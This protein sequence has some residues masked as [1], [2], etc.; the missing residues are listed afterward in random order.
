MADFGEVT[1]T[2]NPMKIPVLTLLG[3]GAAMASAPAATGRDYPYTPVPFTA[4][5]VADS[6]WSPRFE[7]NRLTTVWYDFKKCEETGRIDNFSKAAGLMPGGFRGTPF[8]DSDVYKVIEGAAYILA[9]QPD[10]KLDAY[11]DA[12]IAKIAAAQEPD[13]Y[14]YTA[15]RLFTPE[16]M[17]GMS[18]RTRWSNLEASHELYNVGHLYEAAVAHFQ[19]TGKKTLLNVA[20]KNADFLCATFGP[21]KLQEPPGHQEI[22]IGL[23]KLFRAV[24]NE[25][26][27]DLA[28]FY[29]DLRGRA[30]THRLRGEYQ[31]DHQ[32]VV[33]Q[34][35]AVGHAVRAG[36]LYS[37]V[38]DV[39][40]LTG[41]AEYVAAIDRLW[42]DVTYRKLHLTGGIGASPGG[43]AFGA[44]YEL[45]NRT[46]YLET[47]AAIANGLWNHRMFLL[48]GDAKYLDVLERVLYNGFLSGVAQTGD[49]FFYPNPLEA[50]GRQK[51]N[52]GSNER[53][54]WFG[55]SCCPVNVVRFVPSIA[56]YVYATRGEALYVNLF[57][58]GTAQ[59]QL[60]GRNVGVVQ[61]TRYPWEGTTRLTLDP[62][63]PGAFAVHVRIPGWALGRPLPGDLYTYEG[64]SAEAPVLKVNG[65]VVPVKLEKGFAV[66]DRSWA[67]GDVIELSLPMPVRRVLAHAKV[68]ADKGR[69]A[70][71]RGPVVYCAEGADHDGQALNLALPDTAEFSLEPQPAL[72]NGVTVI[73]ASGLARQ[74]AADGSAVVQPASLK[75]IPYY[76][77]NHR[78]PNEMA[79]WLPRSAELASIA[80]PLTL[81]GTSRPSA[82]HLWEA[83][84][85][86]ALNDGQEPK[87]SADHDLPRFSW[88]PR[89]GSAEWVQY[90][91]KKPSRVESV[92]VYWF[93][94]TGRGQ[95]RV[96]RSWRVMR[97]ENGQWKP[98]EASGAAGVKR[99]AFNRVSFAAVTTSA[100]RLEVQLQDGFSAGI[101]EWKVDGK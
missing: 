98:V 4:V 31:Q 42:E 18:G 58:G 40:A 99:D 94:D 5:H 87:S 80:P 54:P 9:M 77:W 48:H 100:L 35:E 25:K 6:F 66:L 2:N 14:L 85:F 84:T 79:V 51:F 23:V 88:W 95:C 86:S 37:G 44:A 46:A 71:E 16:K 70:V 38:A 91:F 11:L 93:D 20:V 32:P 76:A 74:R 15:R 28:R 62:A 78:G 52:H 69:V 67:K 39:A 17:P 33:E 75:L 61:S 43:E 30:G 10:P 27:L 101:L 53:A 29:V 72:L 8:D 3:L 63:T 50:D 82:S 55:C 92:E 73:R 36:Y 13:G 21:G 89:R 56:G 12:L 83:D 68:Q 97:Q 90:D 59:V 57:A 60:P 41:G 81:A 24:G 49:R 19:A 26:Y 65:A 22:E 96:P 1:P 7:T 64:Q 45:P 47:C 34:K